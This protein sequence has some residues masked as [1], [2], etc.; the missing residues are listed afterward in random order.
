[1]RETPSHISQAVH[2]YDRNLDIVW[3]AGVA[4]R[5]PGWWVVDRGR[6]LFTLVHRDGTPILAELLV[7]EVLEILR[8]ADNRNH[9]LDKLRWIRQ[10][11]D[12][13][14]S[15]EANETANQLDDAK[16]ESERVIHHLET[17]PK[18]FVHI[19]Q[20]AAVPA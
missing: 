15:R 11:R 3:D 5:K 10:G 16:R 1:M 4:G 14:K 18:P 2:A 17:G 6:K 13:R 9:G 20:P 7:D 8:E 12:R 19:H